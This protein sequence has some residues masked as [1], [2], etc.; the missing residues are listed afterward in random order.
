MNRTRQPNSHR[1]YFCRSLLSFGLLLVCSCDLTPSTA[2]KPKEP[3]PIAAAAKKGD[4]E[5]VAALL[6]A[7]TKPDVVGPDGTTALT[8]AVLKDRLL[9]ARMLL[10]AGADPN[11]ETDHRTLV[12]YAARDRLPE[13]LKLLLRFG[14]RANGGTREN[15]QFTPMFDAALSERTN[16]IGVLLGAGADVNATTRF[17]ET[18]LLNA[19]RSSSY[20]NALLLIQNGAQVHVTNVHG[21]T[22]L[23]YMRGPCLRRE[24]LVA[25]KKLQEMF[26]E[27]LAQQEKP[28][29]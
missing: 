4:S 26:R 25:L 14:G 28:K 2:R 11:Y 8:Y 21:G 17:G 20:Q 16:N 27:E 15:P 12:H 10:E 18:P 6:R 1:R 29:R 13:M 22:P 23:Q 3:S 9:I 7:G 24:D 5:S 19:T